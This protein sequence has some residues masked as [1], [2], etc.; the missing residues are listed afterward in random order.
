M[1]PE[2][3]HPLRPAIRAFY[4]PRRAGSPCR[5]RIALPAAGVRPSVGHL[6]ARVSR[7]RRLRRSRLEKRTTLKERAESAFRGPKRPGSQCKRRKRQRH[8]E[9]ARVVAARDVG[10]NRAGL[11]EE[12]PGI[13][14]LLEPREAWK[15]QSNASQHLP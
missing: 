1:F 13:R 14:P 4:K 5:P 6:A 15:K 9:F 3:R 11:L 10:K 7:T 12:G 8:D 2:R